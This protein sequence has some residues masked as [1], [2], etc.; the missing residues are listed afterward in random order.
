MA[1][2]IAGIVEA[3]KEA[4][5]ERATLFGSATQPGWDIVPRD[6]DLMIRMRSGLQG[7]AE[8]YFALLE[9]LRRLTGREVDLIDERAVRNPYLAA[10][11]E[12]TGVVIH[13]AA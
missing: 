11:I 10:E 13:E 8:G 2:L 4:G 1:P 5:V 12:R 7:D 3:C 6:I 9:R